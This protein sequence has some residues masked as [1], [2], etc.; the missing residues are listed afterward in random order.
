LSLWAPAAYSYYSF[1]GTFAFGSNGYG[2]GNTPGTVFAILTP[3]TPAL[4]NPCAHV[5]SLGQ[6]HVH[7]AFHTNA[8]K[9]P[10]GPARQLAQFLSRG[11]LPV[12]VLGAALVVEECI[13]LII[14]VLEGIGS[15]FLTN[16]LEAL[17]GLLVKMLDMLAMNQ[18]VEA[19][20]L[21]CQNID[22]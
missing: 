19:D 5:I 11:L 22:R 7:W 3:R 16:S 10:N 18:V 8:W 20:H 15:L 4:I 21:F 6:S 1:W 17:S 13:K 12:H 2:L 9:L 14:R